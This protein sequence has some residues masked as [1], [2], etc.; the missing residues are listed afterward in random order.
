M[1]N[2][3]QFETSTGGWMERLFTEFIHEEVSN[4]W[5]DLKKEKG[6]YCVF[7]VWIN[8]QNGKVEVELYEKMHYLLIQHSRQNHDTLFLHLSKQGE[9]FE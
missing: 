2:V 1:Q 7:E 3:Y 6:I 8:V 9:E 5:L 4:K